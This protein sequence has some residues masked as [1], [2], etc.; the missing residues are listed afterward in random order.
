LTT[1][2][3]RFTDSIGRSGVAHSEPRMLPEGRS[4]AGRARDLIAGNLTLRLSN[5]IPDV[6]G[7]RRPTHSEN[8][9]P[10]VDIREAAIGWSHLCCFG[11]APMACRTDLKMRIGA[12]L[13]LEETLH[14]GRLGRCAQ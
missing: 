4:S 12:L 1:F 5:R 9:S 2:G 14:W 11:M 6:R 10:V 8:S 13:G 7:R 3:G